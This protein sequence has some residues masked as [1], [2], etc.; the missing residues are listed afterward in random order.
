M[1]GNIAQV[2]AGFAAEAYG[3]LDEP[4]PRRNIVAVCFEAP[5]EQVSSLLVIVK[6]RVEI[7]E[8]RRVGGMQVEDATHALQ[9]VDRAAHALVRLPCDLFGERNEERA[10][11]GRPDGH[12]RLMLAEARAY[13]AAPE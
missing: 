10:I 3:Y 1:K 2:R 13:P 7:D 11:A 4:V 5:G 9:A 6:V 12:F 8:H